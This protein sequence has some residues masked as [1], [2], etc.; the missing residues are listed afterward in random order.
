MTKT[1]SPTSLRLATAHFSDRPANFGVLL[2]N[3]QIHSF[4]VTI[5]ALNNWYCG[6]K[7]LSVLSS[8]NVKIVSKYIIVLWSLFCSAFRSNCQIERR[9]VYFRLFF[10]AWHRLRIATFYL[11]HKASVQVLRQTSVNYKCGT[12]R[13]HIAYSESKNEGINIIAQMAA[14]ARAITT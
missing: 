3:P 8:L 12:E 6:L 7:E 11:S 9:I 1:F 10:H 13:T 2:F 5:W 4:Y 14:G